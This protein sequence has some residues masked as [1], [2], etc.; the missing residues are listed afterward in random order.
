MHL[1][2]LLLILILSSSAASAQ[3]Y[4]IGIACDPN[5]K[6]ESSFAHKLKMTAEKFGHQ[7]TLYNTV[8]DGR[9]IVSKKTDLMIVLTP[10]KKLISN[11]PNFFCFFLHENIHDLAKKY[12]DADTYLLGF[13]P[14][15]VSNLPR[16]ALQFFPTSSSFKE[17]PSQPNQLFWIN[18]AW[19][20]RQ[21]GE[22]YL[23]LFKNL[24]KK[25]RIAIYGFPTPNLPT[26]G[27]L[28]FD[29]ESFFKTASSHG[30]SLVI[31]SEKHRKLGIPTGRIFEALACCNIIICDQHPFVKHHFGDTV[32]YID[33]L[34][35][36]KEIETQICDHLT[37]IKNHPQLAKQ[38]ASDA[39]AIFLREFQL[40]Q[41]FQALI[42][43]F[44]QLPPK[45]SES[46]KALEL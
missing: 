4:R 7:L 13:D 35:S 11:C 45:I 17:T 29:D 3:S 38:M 14:S 12:P 25:N 24:Q 2:S 19:G 31:H 32:L 16:P 36:A 22:K 15:L 46:S 5:F 28:P 1:I 21:C 33:T 20:S 44:E 9:L 39:H 42:N 27:I 23:T 37:W 34:T 43:F 18:A 41:Q 10:L 26:L 40:E 6:G 8:Y 30:I